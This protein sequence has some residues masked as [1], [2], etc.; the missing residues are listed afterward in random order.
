MILNGQE[1]ML[2]LSMDIL[3]RMQWMDLTLT[4]H[5]GLTWV[6]IIVFICFAVLVSLQT[7]SCSGDYLKD[8]DRV[9]LPQDPILDHKFPRPITER[10]HCGGIWEALE[11]DIKEDEDELV[12]DCY[13]DGYIQPLATYNSEVML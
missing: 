1:Y 8:V 11:D 2:I 3:A 12:R 6:M 4:R 10:S 13:A 9:V 7:F 5:T